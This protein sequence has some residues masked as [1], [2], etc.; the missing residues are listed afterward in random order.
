MINSLRRKFVLIS[1]LSITFVVSAVFIIINIL[2]YYNITSRSNELIYKIQ[3]NSVFLEE[4]LSL[5]NQNTIRGYKN[6]DKI[7]NNGIII[8]QLDNDN[9]IEA[10]FNRE[11]GL[12]N[13]MIEDLVEAA[14]E[15]DSKEGYVNY[16]KYT[17]I[18]HG[19]K[20]CLLL[21]NVERELAIFYQFLQN[22]IIV[23]LVIIV[24]TSSILIISSRKIVAPI[25]ENYKKQKQF[26]TDASHELK[27][28]LTII[29]SNADVLEMEKGNSKWLSN[30]HNQVDR[31][32]HLVNSLVAF[33]RVE[34]RE[35][36]EKN[37][38][39]ITELVKSRVED[40]EE[41]ASFKSKEITS[42]IAENLYYNGD[43]QTIMQ[44]VDI[45]LDNAIKY[46]DSHTTIDVELSQNKKNTMLI[47][48]NQASG[49]NQGDLSQVFDRF[50]R[51]DESRNSKIK[52]YGI[53]LSL[54]KLIIDRHKSQIRAYAP[55]DNEFCIEIKLHH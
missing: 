2:N 14:V 35:H 37:K 46:A 23:G 25:E 41:L 19:D 27:T 17:Y 39:S 11:L 5:N 45:L 6:Y 54:A 8:A 48:K 43:K 4:V 49:I 3:N 51:L 30:I 7:L 21:V 20:Y 33:S 38:F 15:E 28:P 13:E 9:H 32:T 55:K 22:S 29:S 40:F 50:Y 26:I 1:T 12:T 44:V 18:H 16:Y 52:G 42:N 31:L 24:I 34:E 53:G 10:L 47:V 36:L